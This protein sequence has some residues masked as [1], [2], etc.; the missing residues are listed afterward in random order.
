MRRYPEISEQPLDA[1]TR[2]LAWRYG[3]ALVT[4]AVL[5]VAGQVFVQASLRDDATRAH[6]INLGGRQRVLS[7]RVFGTILQIQTYPFVSQS[8]RDLSPA[9]GELRSELK[10]T[11]ELLLTAHAEL[12][13]VDTMMKAVEP[14]LQVLGRGA[15]EVLRTGALTDAQFGALREHQRRFRNRMDRI[16][17]QYERASIAHIEGLRRTEMGLLG[18]VLLTLFLE[19]FLVFWPA[20][21][22][23]H[24][25]IEAVLTSGREKSAILAAIPD[26]V[27][28]VTRSGDISGPSTPPTTPTTSATAVTHLRQVLAGGHAPR[29]LAAIG[30]V[31]DGGQIQALD[32]GVYPDGKRFE[33]R[34]APYD[35]K[36]VMVL[37]RDVTERRALE[38]QMLDELARVQK[39][40]GCE[41]HDGVCQQLIGLHLMVSVLE[42]R[43]RRGGEAVS[44]AELSQLREHLGTSAVEARQVSQSLFPVVLTQQGLADALDLLC[45]GVG[46]IHGVT[47]TCRVAVEVPLSLEGVAIH[48]YRIAQEAV[49]NAVKHAHATTIALTLESVEHAILLTITDDGIGMPAAATRPRGIGLNSMHFRSEAIGACLTIDAREGGGTVVCCSLPLAATAEGSP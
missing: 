32:G 2:A 39:E 14:D 15:A 28:L 13:H 26:P 24:R 35:A 44:V 45:Q 22:R 30:Q 43:Q 10:S 46:Q 36:T 31:L 48:L 9:L 47:C 37:L 42:D 4:V 21:R 19:G 25:A 18:W 34:L 6:V 27:V 12:T 33:L 5:S 16:V 20:L 41:I 40:M 7:E 11:W 23:I 17:G 38:R 1:P 49:T 8:G 3:L 29:T